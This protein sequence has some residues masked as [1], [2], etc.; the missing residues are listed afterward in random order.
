MWSP[1]STEAF[2]ACPMR[3]ALRRRGAVG[4]AS[5]WSPG[6]TAGSMFHEAMAAAMNLQDGEVVRY[7]PSPHYITEWPEDAE[8]SYGEAFDR[9]AKAV[10]MA[11]TKEGNAL[12]RDQRVLAT[13]LNLGGPVDE[14]ARHGR[15][16]GT[17]DLLTEDEHGLAVT[18]YKTHWKMDSK[19][20]DADLR[21]T[22]RSWQF[23]QYAYRA[24]EIYG[25]PVTC[26]RKL[27]VA[28]N[29]TVRV[30]P[31]YT[32]AIT[33][34][35]LRVWRDQAESAWRVM[36]DIDCEGVDAWRN[37]NACEK[38]GWAWRCEYYNH[39]WDGE[40]LTWEGA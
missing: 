33:Q 18:D 36:D 10:Q 31:L 5:S 39:C 17:L 28:F 26:V 12:R 7:E 37:E 14:A 19:Y 13:E 32:H 38:Y 25:R 1:S 34:E 27:L 24:Q 30:W 11:L 29:P 15:Y 9:V 35:E 6:L 4:Q 20:A 21:A 16:W 8:V 2:L 40:P 22:A 3:W 23:R